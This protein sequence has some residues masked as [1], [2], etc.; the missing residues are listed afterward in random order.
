MNEKRIIVG[1]SGATGQIY[2]I[3][4][5]QYLKE[6]QGIEVH[7]ILSKW[8][9]KTIELETDWAVEQVVNMAHYVHDY[10][11]QAASVSSGSFTRAG[12]VI[13][14]CSIKTLSAI[15]NSY[16]DNLLIRAADVTLK[17][18]KP[19]ILVLRETPLHLGHIRLM[20][21][22]TE[23]GA[24]IVPPIPAFYNRPTTIDEIIDQSIH[25]VLDLLNLSMLTANRWQ[26]KL[27][28]RT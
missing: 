27:T 7:L 28:D 13:A 5:L 24:I 20:K 4:L 2:G 1:L 8:A 18:R 11:N 22:V 12:M 6:M 21:D 17:E 9:Q 19:L 16:N 14:P 10:M 15:A 23:A 26:G 25:R 3:R